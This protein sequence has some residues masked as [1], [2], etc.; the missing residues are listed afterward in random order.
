[1]LGSFG[2]GHPLNTV[3]PQPD[4]D[5]DPT[6]GFWE[7]ETSSLRDFPQQFR[8]FD[9][10]SNS[11]HTLS[12]IATNVDPAVKEVSPAA[13]S[14]GNAIAAARIFGATPEI[15]ADNTSHAVNVELV[16]KLTAEMQAIIAN[17][18]EPI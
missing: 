5:G 17:V 3:T 14:R 7:V 13:T 1:M 11:D 10:Y 16:V 15:M 6:L 18:G 4:P 9:I 12:I 2:A 8:I